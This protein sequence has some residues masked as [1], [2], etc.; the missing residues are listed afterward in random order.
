MVEPIHPKAMPVK[1]SIHCDNAMRGGGI[2]FHGA[3]RRM[4]ARVVMCYSIG[5]SRRKGKPMSVY[6]V[7]GDARVNHAY[8]EPRMAAE[9]HDASFTHGRPDPHFDVQKYQDAVDDSERIVN[10]RWLTFSS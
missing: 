2:K 1:S 9:L 10:G 5:S 6:D 8:F 7:F 3:A 4:S